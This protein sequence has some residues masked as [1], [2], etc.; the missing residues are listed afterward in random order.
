M[1]Q[2]ACYVLFIE[3][4]PSAPADE[5]RE[6]RGPPEALGRAAVIQRAYAGI[7]ASKQD[8][9]GCRVG[10]DE[11]PIADQ[12]VESIRTLGLIEPEG[13]S[14][15]DGP[16]WK[17]ATQSEKQVLSIVQTAIACTN[18][19]VDRLGESVGVCGVEAGSPVSHQQPRT[20]PNL[21]R[22]VLRFGKSIHDPSLIVLRHRAKVKVPD[23][24]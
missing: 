2:E 15:V 18:A 6:G 19:A 16:P 3:L 11:A 23:A 20:T 14:A 1:S 12:I 7:I 21:A 22:R 17:I 13:K 10:Y 4:I 9:A 5:V 8:E 24:A